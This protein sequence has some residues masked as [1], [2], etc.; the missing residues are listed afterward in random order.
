MAICNIRI[1]A[2]R[3][4]KV[5]LSE[6]RGPRDRTF[7]FPLTMTDGRLEIGYWL[8]EGAIIESER[9][10]FILGRVSGQDEEYFVVQLKQG[11]RGSEGV[12]FVNFP[13]EYHAHVQ[14][15]SLL[16]E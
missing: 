7:S 10:N 6:E 12:V 9:E 4:I 1:P 11:R 3:T 2:G 14:K 13:S 16:T 15:R 8:P 5:G